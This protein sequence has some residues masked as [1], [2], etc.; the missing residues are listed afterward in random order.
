[1]AQYR[2]DHAGTNFR[3]YNRP[4]GASQKIPFFLTIT[5]APVNGDTFSLFKL[6]PGAVLTGFMIDLPQLDSG[7]PTATLAVGDSNNTARYVAASQIARVQG[8][9]ISDA[10]PTLATNII[11]AIFGTLPRLYTTPDDLRITITAAVSAGGATSGSIQGWV[12]YDMTGL[13][14]D[15]V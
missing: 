15:P 7:T 1:M 4:Q 5:V 8:K 3:P 12:S 13:Y 14:R 11:G 9:I 10:S 6:P 2:S